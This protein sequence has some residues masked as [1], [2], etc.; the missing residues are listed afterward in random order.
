MAVV[1][2]AQAGLRAARAGATLLQ[3]RAPALTTREIE[4]EA[5]LLVEISP[6]PVLVSSRADLALAVGAAGVNLPEN[7]IPV[8]EARRLLGPDRLVGRSVHS[9][10]GAREAAA[11]GADYLL[12]GPVFET[13]SHPRQPPA[14]FDA[15]TEVAAGVEVPVLAIGGLT[16]ERGRLCLEAGAAGYAAIRMFE[17]RPA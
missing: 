15:L 17:G 9:L 4:L 5:D 14:G 2:S 7:D 11:D 12:F 13:R 10:A 8:A 6:V 1:A 3:L 16:A